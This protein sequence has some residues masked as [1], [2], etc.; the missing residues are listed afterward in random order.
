MT[1]AITRLIL[2]SLPLGWLAAQELPTG[3][4]DPQKAKH[5]AA[6]LA[7]IGHNQLHLN[8]LADAQSNCD[9]A[10]KLDPS[11]EVAKDCLDRVATM[12]VDQDLNAAEGKLRAGDK[13]GAIDIASKWDG[14]W[15]QEEQQKRARGILRRARSF[16]PGELFNSLV[17]DWLRQVLVAL[18]ILTALLLGLLTVR[19]LWREWLR[20]VWYGRL[21]TITRWKMLPL[22]EVGTADG[23]AGRG[24]AAILDALSRLGLE[25]ERPVWQAKLLLLRPTPPQNHEPAIIDGFLSESLC[26]VL[27]AP[28][29][30]DLRIQ[31]KLH[32]IE[33][34]QAVQNLQI[35]T[36]AGI[37]VGSVARLLR[38]IVEWFNAGAPTISGIAEFTPERANINLFASGGPISAAAVSATTK[39]A[40][41]IEPIQLSAERAAFKFLFRMKYPY[42]T[43]DEIDGFSALRQAATRF[44]QYVGTV[45]GVGDDANTRI[46]S[47]EHAAFNLGFFRTSIPH[48]EPPKQPDSTKD[49]DPKKD[50]S[51]REQE[52]ERES[53]NITDEIRQATLLAE[54]VAH[55]L[56]GKPR[57]LTLAI[58]CFRQLQDW[59]GTPETLPLRQQ[60]MYNEAIVWRELGSI[61]QCVLLLTNLI[62]ERAPDTVEPGRQPI[63]PAA[64]SDALRYPARLARLT[65]FAKYE[66]GDW[67]TLPEPRINLLMTDAEELAGDLKKL[68]ES[69][70]NARDL[71]L[72]KYMH[73]EALRALGHVEVMRA[74]MGP[75]ARF[76]ENSRPL[77]LMQGSLT[78]GESADLRKGV[79]W[80]LECEELAP[81]SDL[82]CDLAE[83]Y[84]LLKEFPAAQGYARHATLAKN[85][86]NERG[87]YLAAESCLLQDTPESRALAVQYA[88]EYRGPVTLDEF[89]A[90][91]KELQIPEDQASANLPQPKSEEP[92]EPDGTTPAQ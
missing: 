13:K 65:S 79:Q 19:K 36:A 70:R 88:S 57:H 21:T 25:L 58:D 76:Y 8:R 17:P 15:V 60:A 81:S 5:D 52:S 40:S 26:P 92:G 22:K 56:V 43:D 23:A 9:A 14:T 24:T 64:V 51:K 59:P 27:L 66:R 78:E 87:Y 54:G 32:D 71:R 33:L 37:D 39:A 77:G 74:K 6:V 67:S 18:I 11:N 38:S 7:L 46:S 82:Y 16:Y 30:E 50:R 91:R 12:L 42:L 35:R 20:G 45:P 31:W 3:A 89:Q 53:L 29:A 10:F 86:Y 73:T 61:G 83:G 4:H 55:A 1:L 62:G 90:I 84:L 47:L 68:Q 44:A 49:G 75:A 69:L 48:G 85:P 63:S 72:A 2:V 34:D 41:G 28:P 80:M